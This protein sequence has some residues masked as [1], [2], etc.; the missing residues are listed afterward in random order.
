MKKLIIVINGKGGCGKD[1]LINMFGKFYSITNVN[2]SQPYKDIA[3]EYGYD[4]SNKTDK[5]RKFIS[6]IKRV[7]EESDIDLSLYY[8]IDNLKEF[9]HDKCTNIMFVHIREPKNIDKFINEA[10]RLFNVLG[11]TH[12]MRPYIST[13]L[14]KRSDTDE[15]IYNNSSD[16]DV[17]NYKYDFVYD[18][19]KPENVSCF[20]FMAFAEENIIHRRK[21]M[22]TMN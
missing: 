14:I 11:Y 16:D 5:W 19:S 22:I 10:N 12:M 13:L 17:E 2:S 20:D 7:F 6:D 9:L 18:N 8:T 1:T 15:K 4:E 3:K 21:E